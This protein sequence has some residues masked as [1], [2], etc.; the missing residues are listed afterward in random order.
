MLAFLDRE[1]T[2][3]INT[4]LSNMGVG[5]HLGVIVKVLQHLIHK[6]NGTRYS[7]LLRASKCLQWKEDGSTGWQDVELFIHQ[8]HCCPANKNPT[9]HS[10]TS[11]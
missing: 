4:D 1:R 6:T 9:G 3:I 2:F 10:S 5:N 11:L 7:S 8:C